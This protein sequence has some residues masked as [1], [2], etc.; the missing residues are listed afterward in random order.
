MSGEDLPDVP[1]PE[2][3]VEAGKDV[4]VE[5]EVVAGEKEVLA[6]RGRVITYL[7]NRRSLVTMSLLS[8][9]TRRS[10]ASLVV[11]SS[12]SRYSGYTN[13]PMW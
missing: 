4:Q 2:G 6:S 3:D 7:E 12:W 5:Q 9:S 10:G 13:K 1:G 11:R 8:T